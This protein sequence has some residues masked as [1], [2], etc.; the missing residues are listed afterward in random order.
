MLNI[1]SAIVLEYLG[2]NGGFLVKRAFN[3]Y[4]LYLLAKKNISEETHFIKSLYK[5][6]V[7]IHVHGFFVMQSNVLLR[8]NFACL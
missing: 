2:I 3:L 8:S 5:F 7:Y 1:C 6:G 4:T